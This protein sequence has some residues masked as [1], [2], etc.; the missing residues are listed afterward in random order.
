MTLTL[1]P[2]IPAD[3]PALARIHHK[4][5]TECYGALAPPDAVAALT[6]AHRLR[7]WTT[8]LQASDPKTLL[9]LSGQTPVGLVCFG[10]PSDLI[11]APR[12][13]VRHLYLLADHR[14]QGHGMRLLTAALMTLRDSGFPGAALAV[15][16]E[17][18]R[19]RGF[20]RGAGGAEILSFADKGPLWRSRNR[21][22]AWDF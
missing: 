9:A 3:A 11:F 21:L 10:S 7:G 14:G 17:N 22:V 8:L 19:A 4:V 1:R 13:E 20:Y 6:E 18:T 5:W 12:G 16:E 2:A 15:V